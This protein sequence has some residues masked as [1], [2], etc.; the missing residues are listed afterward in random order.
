LHIK[1]KEFDWLK[2]GYSKDIPSRIKGYGL[3]DECSCKILKIIYYDTGRS[4]KA[5]ELSI[6]AKF[7][8]KY[9]LDQSYMKRFHKLNGFTE[10]Y[11]IGAKK[12]LLSEF[13]S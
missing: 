3:S 10:C 11:Q 2:L 12:L 4:A 13:E 1:H 5:K 6:H 7:K 8:E 9:R